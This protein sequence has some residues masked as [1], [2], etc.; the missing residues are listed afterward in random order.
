MKTAT[1]D[2]IR[3]GDHIRVHD[4]LGRILDATATSGVEEGHT[5]RVVWAALEGRDSAHAVPWPIDD[6]EKV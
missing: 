3:P 6:V 1:M 5:F 4:A 2:E